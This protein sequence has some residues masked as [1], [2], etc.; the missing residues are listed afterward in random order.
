MRFRNESG[1]SC[2]IMYIHTHTHTHIHENK[3]SH[4]NLCLK[5]SEVPTLKFLVLFS[6]IVGMS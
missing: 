2:E 1:I 5:I 6:L 3:H 4:K